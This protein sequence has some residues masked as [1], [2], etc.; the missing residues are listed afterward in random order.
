MRFWKF[1][2]GTSQA[3]EKEQFANEVD[4]RFSYVSMKLL[5]GFGDVCLS[6]KMNFAH[7]FSRI[8]FM[9]RNCLRV[10]STVLL[11]ECAFCRSEMTISKRLVRLDDDVVQAIYELQALLLSNEFQYNKAFF[12]SHNVIFICLYLN[13]IRMRNVSMQYICISM[14]R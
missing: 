7:L 11:S 8:G 6:S 2:K 10:T 3:Q 4:R 9:A 12:I 13:S 5:Q 14:I 1:K